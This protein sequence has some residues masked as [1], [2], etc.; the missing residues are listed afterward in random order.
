[1]NE[2]R[3]QLEQAF[4]RAHWE[5]SNRLDYWVGQISNAESDT[6]AWDTEEKADL[7]LKQYGNVMAATKKALEEDE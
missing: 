7:D 6:A 3:E 4:Y 1:M 2:G 5:W